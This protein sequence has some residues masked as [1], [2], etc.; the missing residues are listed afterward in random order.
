MGT[1]AIIKADNI[2]KA[3]N[4]ET[5]LQIEEF[6]LC[7]GD[8]HLLMGPNGS[9]KTTLLKILSL[10]DRDFEGSLYYKDKP[11]TNY[12]SL[13][14]LRRKFGVI[15]Q[16][17]YF[18]K[19]SVAHNIT[20]PLKLRK[21]DKEKRNEKLQDIAGKLEIESLLH[22]K[23]DQLSGGERQKVSIARALISDPDVLFVDEP[24][25]NLDPENCQYFYALF[26][27]LSEWDITILLITHDQKYSSYEADEITKLE[28]GRIIKKRSEMIT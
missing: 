20:L 15:W 17:P 21:V 7:Q 10:I 27:R 11:V 19:G 23:C 14:E 1:K 3:Y 9:G 24:T 18:F 26:P 22:R 25:N 6:K 12:P 8:L 5:V 28:N 4:Q 16:N 2:Q 13:L